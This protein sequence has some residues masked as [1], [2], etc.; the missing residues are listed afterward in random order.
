MSEG[1]FCER[2]G[3]VITPE[4]QSN[5]RYL[6]L[7]NDRDKRLFPEGLQKGSIYI[8]GNSLN[9]WIKKV[10]RELMDTI[11]DKLYN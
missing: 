11:L 9:D 7:V 3:F 8:H 5:G 1:E 4:L 6:L 2:H 10:H